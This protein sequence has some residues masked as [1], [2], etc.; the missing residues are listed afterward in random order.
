MDIEFFLNTLLRRKWLLLGASLLAAVV[1][2]AIMVQLPPKFRANAQVQTGIVDYRGVRLTRSSDFV[3]KFQ[4][5]NAFANMITEMTGRA[6]M[7]KL[8][9]RMLMHDLQADRPFRQADEK[10]LDKLGIDGEGAVRAVL[11]TA[12]PL[13]SEAAV[14]PIA[15]ASKAAEINRLATAYG[16]DFDAIRELMEV[17]RLGETDYLDISFITEDPELSYFLVSEYVKMFIQDFKLDQ[18]SEE[19]RDLTFYTGR[20]EA[21]KHEIDSFQTAINDYRRGNRVVDL[22]EQQTSVVGQ[23]SQIEMAIE[24]RRREIRGYENAVNQV[25]DKVQTNSSEINRRAGSVATA[26]AQLDRTKRD[27]I[28]LQEQLDDPGVDVASIERR[29]EDKKAELEARVQSVTTLKRLN[30]TKIDDRVEGL[31]ERELDASIELRAARSA[32]ASM[33]A[34]ANRLRGRASSLVNDEAF[35]S[36]L[37][38]E[39]GILRAEYNSLLEQRD[40]AEVIYTRSEHPLSIV[41]PPRVPE[42]HESRQIPLV[43]AFS[44][45]AMATL[46]SLGLFMLAL[47]D[48]RLRSPDQM[49]SILK[50]DPVVSL[51]KIDAKKFSLSRLFGRDP[52]PES[53]RRWLEG[54]RTLRYEVEQSGKHIFQVTSLTPDAGK[55]IVVAALATALGKANNRVLIVDANFK[56]NTLSAHNN[57]MPIAHPFEMGFDPQQLPRPTAWF[58][59]TDIDVIGNLG[60]NRSFMEVVAGTDLRDKLVVLRQRYDFILFESSAMDLYADSREL[61]EYTEGIICVLDADQ[62]INASDRDSLQWLDAQGEKLLGLVLNRVDLKLLK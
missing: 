46:M 51:T 4:V 20:V 12:E 41:E 43:A 40:A 32:V 38:S 7:S 15:A 29:I 23:I 5:D 11:V 35:L 59:I 36:Q 48:Q 58:D 13:S 19:L 2:V 26:N 44:S 33:Q 61:A 52:L 9:E 60:G 53:E 28:A 14:D 22:S 39:L 47:L 49:R 8:T 30:D 27:L 62:K 57:V 21:K 6:S 25:S 55:S 37:S 16:Y 1:T 31:R 18:S 24:Q 34:E 56:N 10:V 42:E 45:V 17:T 54:V 3:Q 50:R